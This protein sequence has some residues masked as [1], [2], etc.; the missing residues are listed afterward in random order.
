MFYVCSPVSVQVY[1]IYLF[2][3]GTG[4]FV[5]LFC[6]FS[7][8]P[9]LWLAYFLYLFLSAVGLDCCTQAFSS[10]SEHRLLGLQGAGF[11]LLWFLLLRTTGSRHKGSVVVAH[12]L[13]CPAPCGIFPD[14]GSNPGPLHW[15]ADSHWTTREV[16]ST[17]VILALQWLHM[18]LY[19]S[20]FVLSCTL[21]PFM[22]SAKLFEFQNRPGHISVYLSVF[23]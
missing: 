9:F 15:R 12:R 20:S 4:F 16:P 11:S 3:S 6:F 8:C 1:E 18:W 21:K 17:D 19:Y 22:F 10:Y 7:I 2:L 5:F 13:S 23:L 14:Q